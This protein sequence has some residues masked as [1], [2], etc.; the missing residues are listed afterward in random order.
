MLHPFLTSFMV[1]HLSLSS[2]KLLSST[3]IMFH[4]HCQYAELDAVTMPHPSSL[5]ALSSA[6]VCDTTKVYA[7]G[8]VSVFFSCLSG[9]LKDKKDKK[10]QKGQRRSVL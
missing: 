5:S 7:S 6:P 9:L 3:H 10:G 4:S 2:C 1:H 8:K